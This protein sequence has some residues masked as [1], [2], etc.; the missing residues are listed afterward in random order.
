MMTCPDVPELLIVPALVTEKLLVC[1]VLLDPEK[2]CSYA[3]V[4]NVNDGIV[5]VGELA[6]TMPPVP[7]AVPA[8]ALVAML[9]VGKDTV[10]ENVELLIAG[11]GMD[12]LLGSVV[13]PITVDPLAL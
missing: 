4:A 5:I 13:A 10:P 8:M 9:P 12:K 7:V 2:I 11:D 3:P 1:P 6:R